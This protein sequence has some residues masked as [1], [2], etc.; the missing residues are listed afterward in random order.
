MDVYEKSLE[1]LKKII[2]NQKKLSFKI[3]LIGGWAVYAFNPY[4][5]SKDI[6][7]LVEKKNFW[8]LRNFLESLGFRRTFSKPLDK[9]GFAML[10]EEDKI[11]VDVYDE[12][13]SKFEV[14]EIFEKK[15]FEAGRIDGEKV[16]VLERNMLLTLKIFSAIERLGTPKGIKDH[17][18]ILALFDKFYPKIDF[19]FLKSQVSKEK[20]EKT[21]RIIFTDYKKIKSIY[22]MEFLKYQRIKNGV[23]KQL[24]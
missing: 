21:F 8:K 6:D 10:F 23:F 4:M 19:E 3:V 13:I 2:R 22:P 14:D 20:L 16:L 7:L 17:S 15:K 12:K 5:K 11:E 9:K 24:T 18:D 1:V